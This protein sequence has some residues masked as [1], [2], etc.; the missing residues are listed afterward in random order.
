MGQV[1]YMHQMNVLKAERC[2][3]LQAE[4]IIAILEI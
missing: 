3:D 1:Q 2:L 4:I